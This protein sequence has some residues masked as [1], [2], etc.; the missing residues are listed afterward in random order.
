MDALSISLTT[1]LKICGRTSIAGKIRDVRPLAK[2]GGYDFYRAMKRLAAQLAQGKIDLAW[3]LSEA[4]KIKQKPEREHTREGI[5]KF[6][7]WLQAQSLEYVTPPNGV[8]QSDSGL[9]KIRVGPE[10]AFKGKDGKA[11]AMCLWNLARPSLKPYLAAE[12]LR[13]AKQALS[14]AKFE[15]VIFD[16]R[17][18]KLH[19][20]DVIAA[21]SQP[22]L[23][24]D[25]KILEA[26]WQDI[27]DPSL[28]QQQTVS[29]VSSLTLPPSEQPS[30]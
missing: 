29:H 19:K 14:T 23:E 16:M 30:T 18:M 22:Q 12:G 25:L 3:A 24:M 20:G 1:F 4:E 5:K 6:G 13:L 21:A 7:Q 17:A 8:F 10:I 15:F 27:H 11:I 2:P 28:N 9:L 26:I